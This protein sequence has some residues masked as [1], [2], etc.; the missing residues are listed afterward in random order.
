M[1]HFGLAAVAT[2]LIVVTGLGLAAVH[3]AEFQFADRN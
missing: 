2:S 1:A 3:G